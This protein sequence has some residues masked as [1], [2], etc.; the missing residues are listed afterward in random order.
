M[1]VSQIVELRTAPVVSLHRLD[2]H[3]LED[4]AEQVVMTLS[5][6]DGRQESVNSAFVA[7]SDMCFQLGKNLR[8]RCVF[9]LC[10]VVIE[11]LLVLEHEFFG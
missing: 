5:L 7:L 4:L 3:L 10:R 11:N 6:G 1:H 2:K 9:L 8:D